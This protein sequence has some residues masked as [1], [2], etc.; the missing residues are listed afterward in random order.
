MEYFRPSNE[1][2]TADFGWLQSK[3]SFSFGQYYDPQHMG[4]S[5]LRVINDDHVI[6]G[7]GF[8]TH[9]H[10]NMEIISYVLE[11]VIEHKDNFGNQ[12]QVPAGDIQIMSAGKGVTHSEYN[13]SKKEPLK[14]LQIW[15]QPNVTGI[16]PRYEQKSVAQQ[17]PLTPLVTSDGREGSLKMMQDA[18][19]FRLVL[20]PNESIV[21]STKERSAYLHMIEGEGKVANSQMYSGDGFGTT[22]SE[23]LTTQ[24]GNKGMTALWFDLPPN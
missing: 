24:A 12:Y 19:L 10:Q 5:A 9:G 4:I 8:S 16:E 6:G 22:S 15:I 13:A 18:N 2:G 17:G 11:G 21:L 1:R 7:A 23:Q 14:F 3:H 20:K